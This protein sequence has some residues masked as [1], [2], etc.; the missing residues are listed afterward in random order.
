M[1]RFSIW[2]LD[3]RLRPLVGFRTAWF[4]YFRSEAE[5]I[6]RARRALIS[7]A[8]PAVSLLALVILSLLARSLSYPISWF[9]WAAAGGAAV[10]L[11]V[12]AMPIRYG[13]L[14]GPYSGTV[15]DGRRILDLL[16]EAS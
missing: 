7:A 13:R 4:G 8:G 14:F 15:S 9:A 1:V 16:R 5:T 11:A 2:R 3:F 6:S 10:Q 12:T